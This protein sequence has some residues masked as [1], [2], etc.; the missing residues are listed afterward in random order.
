[1]LDNKLYY[2]YFY[3]NFQFYYL[4]TIDVCLS[5]PFSVSTLLSTPEV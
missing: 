1:M 4:S 2:F 3:Q 5:L